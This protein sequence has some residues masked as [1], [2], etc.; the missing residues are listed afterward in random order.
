[1]LK[2]IVS[3]GKEN[4]VRQE[5]VVSVTELALAVSRTLKDVHYTKERVLVTNRGKIFVAIVPVSDDEARRT[6][7]VPQNPGEEVDSE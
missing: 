1:M 7:V 4:K 2:R 5:K 6:I 3:L